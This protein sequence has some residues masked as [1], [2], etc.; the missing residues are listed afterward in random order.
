MATAQ[1]LQN[2]S[3][4][5]LLTPDHVSAAQPPA[6]AEADTTAAAPPP[7][8]R[9]LGWPGDCVFRLIV[10]VGKV[11]SIIGRKGELI[12]KMCE[13]T[14]SRIRVLDAPLGTPD[15]IVLV[16]GR[17][18]TEAALS[19]A[20]D[21]VIRIFKRVFGLSE[22]DSEN[23]ES[24]AGLAFCSIRLLV[25][26]TQAIS[27]IGKQGSLIKSIQ[28]NTSASVRVLSGGMLPI[29]CMDI[30]QSFGFLLHANPL[31]RTD[32]YYGEILYATTTF[33]CYVD[34]FILA[35]VTVFLQE[36]KERS[37]VQDEVQFYATADER[38][39]EIQGETLKVLKAL[40]AVVGHLRKFLV[41]HSVLPLFE[42]NFNAP[43]SQD[44]QAE[45]WSD[46]SLLNS[47]SRTSVFPDMPLPTKRDS[48]LAER[49]S[50]LDS[51]LPS[52]TMS[53]YGQDSSL[54]GVRSSA[55][56]RVSAPIVTTV[57]QTMQIPLSYAED[58]I[59][60]QG[61]NIDYIRRTSGAVLTVQ[62]SR[63]PDE[64]IVEIKGTSSE[65]Q[66]AQQLIQDFIS[67]HKEPVSMNYGRLDAGSRSSYSQLGTASRL[68]SSLSSQPYTGYGSSGLGDYSTFRL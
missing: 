36:G 20:M 35:G 30:M 44:R 33:I 67:T 52:S 15:R 21:A 64:I 37:T 16:S 29:F 68:P 43:I 47:T 42:R 5:N 2:G 31:M 24:T 51:L 57:I 6:E 34:I 60:I 10:P 62:E 4:G 40:E 13:E 32:T 53:L 22:I 14:R 65:V 66:T 45:A 61:T 48:I 8:R 18:E 27:L 23:K 56:G 49:E 50:Q 3:A 7:E 1:P 12:K 54:S 28:E 63:V 38:I 25:A 19:P 9:W 58:I 39:V 59:G 17:E 11:G 46:K 26:S 55:L 41:D